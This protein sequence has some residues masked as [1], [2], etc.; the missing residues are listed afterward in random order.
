MSKHSAKL[1]GLLFLSLL[2]VLLPSCNIPPHAMW[3]VQW[4]HGTTALRSA[5]VERVVKAY[6]T[7]PP[8]TVQEMSRLL[9]AAPNGRYSD[10]SGEYSYWESFELT[11][12]K[13]IQLQNVVCCHSKGGVII[14]SFLRQM[15]TRDSNYLDNK[16]LKIK[17]QYTAMARAFKQAVSS[18]WHAQARHLG[19]ELVIAPSG[20][21]CYFLPSGCK[22][23]GW[24]GDTPNISQPA[25]PIARNKLPAPDTRAAA[26]TTQST[27]SSSGSVLGQIVAQAFVNF[28]SNLGNNL[29]TPPPTVQPQNYYVPVR[30]MPKVR[31]PDYSAVDAVNKY[32]QNKDFGFNIN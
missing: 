9:G 17:T 32:W 24:N 27:S 21:K 28:A 31:M 15:Q 10:H 11:K 3:P 26:P 6:Q 22:I 18:R 25:T 30:T 7:N 14:S 2:G 1:S 16:K 19:K 8:A 4:Q 5:K 13:D 23:N 12:K 29:S 20:S